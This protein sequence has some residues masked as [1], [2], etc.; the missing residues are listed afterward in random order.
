[1]KSF[2]KQRI[3]EK[4]GKILSPEKEVIGTH[5]GIMFFTIGERVGDKKGLIIDKEYRKKYPGR[6]FI[7]KKQ[8]IMN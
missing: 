1:M 3:K 7:A 6:L 4:P 8:K 2:L 5:P